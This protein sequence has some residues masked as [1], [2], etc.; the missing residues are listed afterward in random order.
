MCA[1]V[2]GISKGRPKTDRGPEVVD[3]VLHE[4]ARLLVQEV[5]AHVG[6]AQQQRDRVQQDE[7]VG[8]VCIRWW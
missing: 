5:V 4:R 7:L 6:E 1:C 8:V 3:D 2:S